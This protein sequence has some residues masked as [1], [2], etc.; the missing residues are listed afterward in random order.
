MATYKSAIGDTSSAELRLLELD[1][2]GSQRLGVLKVVKLIAL[3]T[4]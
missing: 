1:V 2:Y 3:L 4:L